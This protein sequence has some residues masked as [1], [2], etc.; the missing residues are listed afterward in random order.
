MKNQST[1]NP[2]DTSSDS[3]VP[4]PQCV[5]SRGGMLQACPVLVFLLKCPLL[6][7]MGLASGTYRP[8]PVLSFLC[9]R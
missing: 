4:K 2:E 6:S 7:G 5:R 1:A 9:S 8:N 3:Q